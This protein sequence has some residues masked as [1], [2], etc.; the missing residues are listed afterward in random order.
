MDG[1]KGRVG[2]ERAIELNFLTLGEV[3]VFKCRPK[4]VAGGAVRLS[5]LPVVGG[6][7]E[8]VLQGR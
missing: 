6:V 2:K 4:A 8:G 5:V 7:A 3:Y 1:A